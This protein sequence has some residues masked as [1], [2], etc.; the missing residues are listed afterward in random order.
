MEKPY[1]LTESVQAYLS[2][3]LANKIMDANNAVK[4]GRTA[5]E[6]RANLT[7]PTTL[8]TPDFVLRRYLQ[9]FHPGML[10]GYGELPDLITEG[11]NVPWPEEV[12]ADLS[13]KLE[14][15]SKEQ[16]A[17][18]SA[19]E[20]GR[21]FHKSVPSSREKVFRMAFT[22]KMDVDQTMDLL[23]AFGMEPYSVRQPLDLI[24]LFCQKVGGS[25]TWAQA[26]KMLEDFLARRPSDAPVSE[27]HAPDPNTPK[28]TE[29]V[30]ADL[31]Q[32][33][34]RKLQSANAQQALVDYM[35]ENAG[36]FISFRDKGEEVF[37]PG[38]SRRRAERYRRLAA[39]LAALYPKLITPVTRKDDASKTNKM[40]RD[41]SRNKI[42]YTVDPKTGRVV[43]PTLVRAMFDGTGWNDLD[44]NEDA[45]RGSFED[46]MH[47]FCSNYKQHIDKVNRLFAGGSNI[48][49][50]DRRDAL[51]F[52]F[53]LINGCLK[54]LEY[55]SDE[56]RYLFDKLKEMT[57]T[58]KSF[59]AAV[60]QT[61]NKIEA[62]YKNRRNAPAYFQGLRQCFNIILAQ[63][64]QENLYLP[65]QFDRFVLLALLAEDPEELAGLIM[66]EAEEEGYS[67]VFPVRSI[68][69]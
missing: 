67:A 23:L 56:S 24:C 42:E 33:F 54:L 3:E 48:A 36:I 21:Y 25:Y 60:G 35:V 44:W 27:E 38:Y 29:M 59:D 50:F 49:F 51:L 11:K 20:W 26:K 19:A 45:P 10:R 63:L 15:L 66:S 61:L 46:T 7:D 28:N 69:R 57:R 14:T 52:L 31:N 65:A 17:A 9:I 68:P 47:K 6:I 4:L 5:S 62:V 53:F 37:L 43:L 22:L 2:N 39:Y 64:D 8:A 55:N 32:L 30:Q 18:I 34:E 40:D 41:R 13:K 1:S 12:L 58:G 16:G